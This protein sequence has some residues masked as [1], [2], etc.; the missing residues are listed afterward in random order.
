M[1]QY[2]MAVVKKELAV[3]SAFTSTPFHQVFAVFVFIGF[4]FGKGVCGC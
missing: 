4:L 3:D 2:F 1:V